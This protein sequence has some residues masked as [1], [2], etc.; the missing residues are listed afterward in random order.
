MLFYNKSYLIKKKKNQLSYC[1]MPNTY[2]ATFTSLHHV[3]PSFTV[4]LNHAPTSLNIN[5][6]T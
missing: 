4:N 1:N 3:K 6:V 2:A 5:I